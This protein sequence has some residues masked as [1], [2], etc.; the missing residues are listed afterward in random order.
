[1]N[2]KWL[3]KILPSWESV[4]AKYLRKNIIFVLNQNIFLKLSSNVRQKKKV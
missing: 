3:T 4:L 1:M 2:G